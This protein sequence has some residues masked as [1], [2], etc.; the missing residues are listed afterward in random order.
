[1]NPVSH[2]PFNKQ[3]TPIEIEGEI[4]GYIDNPNKNMEAFY[5]VMVENTI[6]VKKLFK[7]NYQGGIVIDV[8]ANLGAFTDYVLE[9]TDAT[10]HGFEPVKKFIPYLNDKYALNNKVLMNYM[11][12]GAK[13]ET[14][15]I[16]TDSV[17]LGWNQIGPGRGE[18]IDIITMDSY[19]QENNITDIGM[20]KI[21]VEFY[22]PFVLEGMKNFITTTK[23]LPQIIIE[24]NWD[25]NPYK[26]KCEQVFEW[27]FEYYEDFPYALYSSTEDVILKPRS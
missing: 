4:I 27:L 2:S 18:M 16:Y 17:N 13:Q 23:N 5:H 3:G 22:E 24:W 25:L 9:T 19:I 10:V 8:G 15:N 1:M 20:V 26:E 11:G 21:D 6:P 12:L 7:E 14:V